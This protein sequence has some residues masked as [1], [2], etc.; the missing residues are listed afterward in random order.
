VTLDA[1]V[2]SATESA[3]RFKGIFSARP[4]PLA[5]VSQIIVK[6]LTAEVAAGIPKGRTGVLLKNRDF[7][8]G[9]FGGIQNG[10]LKIGSVLFGTRTFDLAKDVLAVV[11]RARESLPW[12]YTIAARDG[13]V[14][15]GPALSIGPARI[16]FAAASE[17]PV[18]LAELLEVSRRT[19]DPAP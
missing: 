18:A 3:I 5:K 10:Q 4:L 11:L 17:Y 16:A 1:P 9:E 2:Q 7:I 6:P 19:E 15:Y 13:T 8:D 12:R 14:L